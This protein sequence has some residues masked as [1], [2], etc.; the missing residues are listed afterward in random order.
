[1]VAGV[2]GKKKFIYDM[3]GD[4]VNTAARMES[5]GVPGKIQVSEATYRLLA[6]GYDV[7][8]KMVLMR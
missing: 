6:D 1:M 2:I 8:R 4:A 5:H 3:W 7:A